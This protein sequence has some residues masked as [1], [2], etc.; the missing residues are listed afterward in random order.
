M[1]DIN[2]G[3]KNG[4]VTDIV[5]IIAIIVIIAIITVV[6]TVVIVFNDTMIA[7]YG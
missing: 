5:I 2:G 7:A 1:P 3:G 4:T 6:V